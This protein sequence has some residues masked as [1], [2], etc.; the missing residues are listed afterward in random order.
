MLSVIISGDT[1]IFFAAVGEIEGKEYSI[2]Y[3][4]SFFIY[5][6]SILVYS[7][8]RCFFPNTARS[9][10]GVLFRS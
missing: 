4:I 10:S 7:L 9:L 3:I 1:S 2:F 8:L 5:V 6:L